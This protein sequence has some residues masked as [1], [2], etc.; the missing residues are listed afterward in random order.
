MFTC[1]YAQEKGMTKQEL[2]AKL[3]KLVEQL[4]REPYS[5]ELMLLTKE[6]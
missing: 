6:Q 5:N 2:K 3:D 1:G 4:G